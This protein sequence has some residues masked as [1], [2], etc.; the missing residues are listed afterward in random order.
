MLSAI[1]WRIARGSLLVTTSFNV[2][3]IPRL[4]PPPLPI[5]QIADGTDVAP[6]TVVPV[7]FNT[8]GS[9]F[10]SPTPASPTLPSALC[11]PVPCL[12]SLS[13]AIEREV[14]SILSFSFSHV[15]SL[16]PFHTTLS[17]LC[18]RIRLISSWIPS[19]TWRMVSKSGR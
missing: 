4:T 7:P 12:L 18:L 15:P 17:R 5:N 11:I 19:N 10:S 1:L 14:H 3:W 9:T 8:C 16:I 13:S 2:S 6:V